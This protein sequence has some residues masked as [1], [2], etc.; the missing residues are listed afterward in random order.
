MVAGAAWEYASAVSVGS[1]GGE[2]FGGYS[3]VTP[4]P[5]PRI[6]EA[7][8]IPLVC[9][10]KDGQGTSVATG[11]TTGNRLRGWPSRGWWPISPAAAGSPS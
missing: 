10:V 5:M 1:D 4:G 8:G 9:A 11:T 6:E 2:P 3:R 7:S